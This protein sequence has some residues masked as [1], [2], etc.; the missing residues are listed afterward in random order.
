MKGNSSSWKKMILPIG[1]IALIGLVIVIYVI[2]HNNKEAAKSMDYT[3]LQGL[4]MNNVSQCYWNTDGA[5]DV[6]A[7]E[8][9]YYYVTMENM[10]VYFDIESKDVIPVCAKPDCT[11]DSFSCNA[12][13]GQSY[14]IDSIYYYNG[15][16][17]YMPVESGMAK[18]CRIDPSGVTREIVG[19]LLPSTGTN[20]IHLTFQGDYAYAYNFTSHISS[21]EE[22]TEE[23][24]ELSLKDGTRKV[25]YEVTGKGLAIK[26]VK[27]FGDKV[28]FIVQESKDFMDKDNMVVKSRGLYLYSHGEDEVLTVS[29]N[30]IND[31]YILPDTGKMY[32]YVTGEG[33]YKSDI[34]SGQS[35]RIYDATKDFDMCSVSSDGKYVY[36]SNAKYAFYVYVK[37][38]WD[39]KRYVVLDMDGNVVNDIKCPNALELYFGDERYL[40]CR[41]MGSDKLM[42]IDKKNIETA[43]QWTD[44]FSES[45]DLIDWGTEKVN[46]K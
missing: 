26:N 33:L 34:E 25:V 9:G 36:L 45:L 23:L 13:L 6:A 38:Q 35:E 10:I 4:D 17:Y 40:F 30:N 7:A 19:E 20:A 12:Y 1:F 37:D 29:E 31:Y 32:Y 27:S 42:Y 3:S 28:F 18:L 43:T 5:Y 8:N 24:V 16:I 11:H 14:V 39:K 46:N 2:S 44:V 15:Y 41:G 22:F 21:E